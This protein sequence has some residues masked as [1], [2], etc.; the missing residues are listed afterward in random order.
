MKI[1][2]ISDSFKSSVSSLDAGRYLKTG[3]EEVSNIFKV[4]CL[5]VADGGEGTKS[6]LLSVLKGDEILAEVHDPLMRSI[7]TTFGWIDKNKTAIIEMSDASGLA[8]L[9]KEERNPLYTSTYGTGEL[10]KYALDKGA[11]KIFIGLGGSATNDAGAGM[12]RALGVKFNTRNKRQLQPGGKYL[13]DI[14]SIDIHTIDK[15][16]K[17]CEITAITDV[18]NPLTGTNGASRIYA[19]QKGAGNDDI[20]LL[21]SNL[22]YIS[23]II[24]NQMGIEIDNIPGSGSAGGIAAGLVAFCNAKLVSGFDFIAQILSLEKEIKKS[25][26]IITGEGSIDET[27][28]HNKASMGVAL[29]S[30]KHKKPVIAVTGAINTNYQVLTNELFDCVFSICDKPMSEQ[31]AIENAPQLLYNTGMKIGQML[32]I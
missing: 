18:T 28:Y 4:K 26:I 21:E 30:R 11:K 32:K 16:L 2:I 5:P 6:V 1:L 9:S 22:V 31:T 13:K 19:K 29:L 3:I 8:L 15:R 20:E 23:R 25:D 10:I 24:H 7:S 14:I 27:T 12:A 17:H